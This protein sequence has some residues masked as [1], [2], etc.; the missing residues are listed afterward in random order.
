MYKRQILVTGI[1]RDKDIAGIV[2]ELYSF[3]D[4]VIVTR[5]H[6]PRAGAPEH[7]AAEFSR[8]GVKAQAT[9]SI[10][11]ALLLAQSLAGEKDL[12]CVAGSLFIV[13]EAIEQANTRLPVEW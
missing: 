2:A 1:S 9:E 12:V 3:F 11:E 6:H 5:S 7:I 13:A 4:K 8:H 10:S